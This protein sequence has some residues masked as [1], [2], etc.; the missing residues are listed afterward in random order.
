MKF[1][2]NGIYHGFRLMNTERVEEI[3][4][5]SYE[6]VHEKSGARLLFLENS[7]R[8]KVFSI[9]FRTPPVDDTGSAHILEHSVLCGS[10]RYPLKEPFV[11]LLKCSLNTFLNA[12]TFSDKT[13]Y[14]VASMNEADF[15]ILMDVYLDAV[16]NPLI[17]TKK[18]IFLQEGWHYHLEDV[19]DDIRLNG[20]VYNEMKGAF[21]DPEDILAR[22]IESTL[23]KDTAYAFE[24]GGDPDHIPELTYE[25]FLDFHRMYYHPSNSYIYIY[26]DTDIMRHLEYLDSEYLSGYERITP[27]SKILPKTDFSDIEKVA[28]IKY[29]VNDDSDLNKKDLLALNYSIGMADDIKLSIALGILA[30]VLFDSDSS[31]LKKALIDAGI[32]DEVSL[33]YN[34]GILQPVVSVIAKNARDDRVEL[35]RKTVN[36]TFEKLA[37]EGIDRKILSSAINNFEF[38]LRESDSGTYPKGLIYAMTV[39]ES[40]LYGYSPLVLLRYEKAIE[41]IRSEYEDGLFEEI[42][43]KYFIENENSNF[44]ILRPEAGLSSKKDESLKK[45]LGEFKNSL[46]AEELDEIKEETARLIK[47]Q[48]TPDSEEAKATIPHVKIDEIDRDPVIVNDAEMIKVGENSVYSRTDLTK[49]I[50]YF[51]MNSE[52]PIR[53]AEEVHI[54]SL[55]CKSLS[56]FDTKSHDVLEINNMINEGLGDMSFVMTS[57]SDFYEPEKFRAFFTVTAKALSQKED[58]IYEIMEEILTSSVLSDRKKLKELVLEELSKSQ[59]RFLTAS[60]RLVLDEIQSDTSGRAR[61]MTHLYGIGYYE[62][63]KRLNADFDTAIEDVIR[64]FDEMTERILLSKKDILVTAGKD[65]IEESVRKAA[66]FLERYPKK[67]DGKVTLEREEKKN[68]AY[69]LPVTVNYAG[70]GFNFRKHGFEYDG[71]MLVLKKYLSTDYLWNNIRVMGGAYGSFI[72][73]DKYGNLDLV[74]YRDPHVRR[75]YEMYEGLKKHVENISLKDEDLEKLIIGTIS[76]TDMPQPVY[77]KLRE[78]VLRH[79]SRDTY[80]NIRNRRLQILETGV[81]DL[82]KY[83]G[84]FE[85]LNENALKIT[86]GEEKSIEDYKDAFEEVR[87]LF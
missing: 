65:R 54:I 74:T 19:K 3:D 80:E 81:E 77:V 41:E 59:S 1:D 14:P 39:M 67:L 58:R 18:E 25:K 36:D 7:D 78:Y 68:T 9:T 86:C 35:F 75:T 53:S 43:R 2:I 56:N 16:F 22:S 40:W 23:Y 26:G 12:M 27:D 4:S 60:H 8:N 64:G 13:M 17:Y 49:D 62:F 32:A 21:S 83:A 11:E 57:V 55:L 69:I 37:D 61:F 24:S 50:T 29:S 30:K 82:R 5:L 42:I 6:F 63:L 33:S 10:D 66:S 20:V 15:R 47:H 70:E 51:E 34:N 28:E 46:S 71:H 73:T 72:Q 85:A 52:V 38:D 48:N 87:T 79:Y 31:Y 76:D 45:E 44:V 84:V